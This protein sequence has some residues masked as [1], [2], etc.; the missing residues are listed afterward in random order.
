MIGRKWDLCYP[1]GAC[2]AR[3]AT[4]GFNF[5]K[6]EEQAPPLQRKRNPF[7]NRTH[8]GRWEIFCRGGYHPPA[9]YGLDYTKHDRPKRGFMFSC[10]GV[11]DFDEFE[12]PHVHNVRFWIHE[13]GGLY[14]PLR[15]MR[16]FTFPVGACRT[17]MNSNVHT[18]ASYGLEFTKRE[19][20]APPL[21]RKRNSFSNRTHTD[22]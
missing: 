11:Q 4:S 5:L 13:T 20:Q 19:E 16:R 9:T 18:S 2:I 12:C 6:R 3:P 17:S 21:Q 1:V 7:S 8:T 14:P 22:R 10:R 15:V